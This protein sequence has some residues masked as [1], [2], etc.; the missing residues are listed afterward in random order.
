MTKK[1]LEFVHVELKKDTWADPGLM[2]TDIGQAVDAVGQLIRKL[3]R[4]MVIQLNIST[5]GRVINASVVS[6]GNV[7]S[8]IVGSP[9]ILRTAILSG[10][11]KFILLHNHPGGTLT[12]SD[13]DRRVAKRMASAAELM[14]LHLLDFIII[15]D[16][17]SY[18][19]LECEQECLEA[20]PMAAE[21]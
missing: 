20:V 9:E 7:N 8:S 17:D 16:G 19:M 2:V 14:G 3:D 13:E 12:P 10:A 4:E 5:S 18:S 6:I 21:F 1:K 15:A 11:S